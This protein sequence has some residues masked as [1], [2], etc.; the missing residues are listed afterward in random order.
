MSYNAGVWA[1]R[2]TLGDSSTKHALKTYASFAQEDYTTW[3]TLDEFVRDTE[4]SPNTIRSCTKR[5]I[6]MGYLRDTGLRGG[7][8]KQ[9]VIYQMT[10]PSGSVVVEARDRRT[11]KTETLSPPDLETFEAYQIQKAS[12]SNTLKPSQK[13]KASKNE[14]LSNTKRKGTKNVA[15]PYQIQS[16]T[17]PK[18]TPDKGLYG[19]G[20]GVCI[21]R[22]ENQPAHTDEEEQTE[23]PISK[24]DRLW[25]VWPDASGR[26]Q[27]RAVCESHWNANG[28]EQHAE[29]IIAHV[30]AMRLTKHWRTGGDPTPIKYLEQRRWLDGAPSP[31]AAAREDDGPWWEGGDSAIEAQAARVGVSRERAETT[32]HLLVRVARASGK[33]PWID[34]VITRARG[35][36]QAFF[37][38]A[39]EHIGEA[40]LPVDF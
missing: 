5:L 14:T 16:E 22:D 20:V 39:V 6:Q 15:K 12:E 27:Q 29:V 30:Q 18:T 1:K 4:M 11:G 33:G 25:E 36:G 38:W 31:E 2:Q 17:L 8:T 24:F 13:R 23:K 28:L 35:F 19:L 34:Y 40:L 3:V 37:Q 32:P 10:A 26:K 9:I 7:A 21:A